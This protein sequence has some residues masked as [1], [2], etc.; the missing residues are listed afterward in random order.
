MA[1]IYSREGTDAAIAAAVEA[2]QPP[3]LTGFATTDYVA[4]VVADLPAAGGAHVGV[5]I[6]ATLAEAQAWEAAHPGQVALTLEGA[7]GEPAGI[8]ATP[9]TMDDDADT[10][11]IPSTAGVEYLVAGA[12]TPAGVHEVGDADTTITVTAR[13]TGNSP[14][15]GE[16]VWPL[17]FTRRSQTT[18]LAATDFSGGPQAPFVSLEASP[19]TLVAGGNF[20]TYP[21][22]LGD[23]RIAQ[24]DKVVELTAGSQ[25]VLEPPADLVGIRQ[26]VFTCSFRLAESKDPNATGALAFHW[27]PLFRGSPNEQVMQVLV[28]RQGNTGGTLTLGGASSRVAVVAQH[29]E[30]IPASGNM[31]VTVTHTAATVEVDGQLAAEFSIDTPYTLAATQRPAV[32]LMASA[33]LTDLRIEAGQ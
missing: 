5:P 33:A 4:A 21:L 7:E 23:G 1:I 2:V 9:P 10:Y 22:T 24:A 17:Y 30:T 8:T 19:G 11:T 18:V 13:A 12:V 28:R 20:A 15:V 29:M 3:D 32:M 27:T 26:L 31:V 14:L 16:S 25:V 6:F